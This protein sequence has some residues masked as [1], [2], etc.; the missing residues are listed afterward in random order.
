MKFYD[1]DGDGNVSFDEFLSGLRDELTARRLAMVK[2]AFA[3]MDKDKSGKL[4][5]SD[6]AGIYDVA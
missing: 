6:I 4:T 3:M 5:A 2:K 1:V